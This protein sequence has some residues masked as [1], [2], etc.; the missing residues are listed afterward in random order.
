MRLK[1][2]F[3]ISLVGAFLALT[4][5]SLA[6]TVPPPAPVLFFSDLTSGPAT[7][8]SDTTYSANGG[9]YVTLYGNFLAS[10][11]VTLNGANCVTVVSQPTVWMWYQRMVVKL[12]IAC[13]TGNFV[14]TTS[15]G[16]S[17]GIPFTVRA[18]NI[19]YVSTTGNDASTGSFSAPWATLTKAKQTMADGDITYPENGVSATADDGEGWGSVY[20]LRPQW[21]GSGTGTAY[22]R[23]LVAYPGATVTLGN[24]AAGGA[25]AT[26]ATTSCLGYYTFAGLTLRGGDSAVS[27]TQAGGSWMYSWRF[28]GNDLSAPN[29]SISAQAG[30]MDGGD[31]KGFSDLGNNIHNA[32]T[33]DNPA[34][35]TALYHG[36]YFGRL[37]NADIGW[38]TI[39]FVY[40]CR[41]MQI[42]A[43]G[44]TTAQKDF[45]Y[46][47]HDNVIHDTQC[48]GIGGYDNIDASQGYFKIYNNVIYNAGKGPYVDGGDWACIYLTGAPTGGTI[49]VYNNTLYNC[50]SIANP[51][52][53][54][55]GAFLG[56][57]GA[58]LIQADNNII[59]QSIGSTNSAG[60]TYLW[61]ESS[62]GSLWSGKNNLFFSGFGVVTLASGGVTANFTNSLN[63]DPSFVNTGTDF[64]ISSSSPA[65]GAGTT[66][67]LPTYDHDGLIRPSPPSIGASEYAPGAAAAKPNPP[68]NLN[69]VVN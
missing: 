57:S 44:S 53:P 64:H 30:L 4:L 6:I 54:S 66:T 51:P 55:I 1:W 45:N 37:Q 63:V 56:G 5:Q 46:L 61:D 32:A 10:P 43:S 39:A 16:T 20:T 24:V 49:N 38:N 21:C 29:A 3:L 12:G 31:I 60:H 69:V 67:S 41:G 14:V 19:Y 8:N 15:G 27:I 25:M 40:G 23:A 42:Y 48:D 7:G 26:R 65:N 68:T 9:A 47:I 36:W 28:V 59:Y 2:L 52:Y 62:G 17:N 13:T 22:P 18:G 50:G 11:T 35:V 33:N 58:T 34:Q